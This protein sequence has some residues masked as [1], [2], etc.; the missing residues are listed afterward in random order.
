[1][2]LRSFSFSSKKS[3]WSCRHFWFCGR[4]MFGKLCTNCLKTL[5]R[6]RNEYM[7]VTVRVD[8]RSL[9][10]YVESKV[11]SQDVRQI[12][13]RRE[14]MVSAKICT[15]PALEWP[16]RRLKDLV[17]VQHDGCAMQKSDRIRLYR[18]DIVGQSVIY[19]LI[20]QHLS[21]AGTYAE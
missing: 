9:M 10:A 1:M 19:L 20:A 15:F 21:S 12:I 5:H 11:V 17:H 14:W 18:Q 6:L 4:R 16:L 7:W 13:R 2:A 3:G 8:L